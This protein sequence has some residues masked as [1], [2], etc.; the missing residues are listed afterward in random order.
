[1][2][3]LFNCA[4]QASVILLIA[5]GCLSLLRKKSAAFRHC[6][7]STALVFAT[8]TPLFNLLTPRLNLSAL[9]TQHPAVAPLREQISAMRLPSAQI[10]PVRTTADAR[11]AAPSASSS[12]SSKSFPQPTLIFWVVWSTGALA[13]VIV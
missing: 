7:L 4:I 10:W 13:G 5:F 1:M 8:L 2:T 6:V 3:F 11:P 12:E 9:V